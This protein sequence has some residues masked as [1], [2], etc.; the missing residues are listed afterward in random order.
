MRTEF[1]ISSHWN[2][3]LFFFSLLVHSFSTALF[4]SFTRSLDHCWL[5]IFVWTILILIPIVTVVAVDVYSFEIQLDGS[6]VKCVR[7]CVRVWFFCTNYTRVNDRGRNRKKSL[8]LSSSNAWWYFSI[9]PFVHTRLI[10][11]R[12][13]YVDEYMCEWWFD[14][15]KK[16]I[17][18]FAE[19]LAHSRSKHKHHQ[20]SFHSNLSRGGMLKL[21]LGFRLSAF[22]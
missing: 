22:K 17:F 6:F 7:K 5:Y 1:I 19:A 11:G 20:N 14:V 18:N 9:Y 8:S 21:Q 13:M 4:N 3:D 10:A 16:L 2:D 12:L 15:P